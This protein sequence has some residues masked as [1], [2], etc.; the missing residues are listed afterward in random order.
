[1]ALDSNIRGVSSGVGAEVDTSNQLK[2]NLPVSGLL[3]GTVRDVYLRDSTTSREM[4]VTEEGEAYSASSRLMFY[5]NM[6]GA[7]MLNNQF[8][9]QAT[10]MAGALTGG[11][12]RLNSGSITTTNTGIAYQTTRTFS[13][14][15]GQSMR[16]KSKVRHTGGA[17]ANKQAEL[18]FGM[19]QVAANQAGATVEF[20]GF[21]WTQGG[22]LIGVME[23]STGGAV[24]SQTININAG[25][26]LTDNVSREYEVIVTDNAVEFWIDNVYQA[27]IKFA[28]DAPGI[29]KGAAYPFYYRL[30][31]TTATATA[32]LFD[33]GNLSVLKVGAEADMAISYRQALMGRASWYPQTGLTG[34]N[35]NTATNT[36]SGTAPTAST[37][38]NAATAL[39]G[40]GGY[41]AL[42]AASFTAANVNVIV[43]AYQNPAVPIA[44]GAATDTRNLVITDLHISPLV[45]T[46]ALT[47]G[48][49]VLNW[50]IT[51]GNTAVSQATTDAAGT[52]ALG[53]KSPRIIPLSAVDIS[54]SAQA[55]AS[56]SA[57]SGGSD[58]TFQ[59]PIVVHPGEFVSVGVRVLQF[60][61]AATAGVYS[62]SVGF[63]GYWD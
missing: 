27:S 57:R 31:I 22:N 56:V 5:S 37:G 30:F 18:G 23:Y 62:G 1:M 46:T 9:S 3:A 8:N 25:I 29:T 10:T 11:W 44:A 63:G 50:F 35:G 43:A 17:L 51:V 21:R 42:N 6:N 61:A 39:T 2:V 38:S 32:P 16:G 49:A 47:A 40:L 59:T 12:L 33:I 58:F 45:V 4:R 14:E 54:T 24:T 20:L 53:S 26:P 55:A 7:T 19:Y 52:T 13:I 60:G 28:A 15:T 36:A 48:G 34:T 41:F